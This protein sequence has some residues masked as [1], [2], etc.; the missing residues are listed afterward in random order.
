[1]ADAKVNPAEEVCNILIASSPRLLLVWHF[2][3]F[4]I[5]NIVIFTVR[6]FSV[7][8]SNN[9]QVIVKIE[10]LNRYDS[11]AVHN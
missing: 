5:K 9:V 10:K 6:F 2:A 1:M 11:I 4:L 3:I 7:Y 8:N